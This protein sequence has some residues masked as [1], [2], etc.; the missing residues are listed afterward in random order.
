MEVMID[1]ETMGMGPD[2]AIISIGAVK[3]DLKE[4]RLGD[5][6]YTVVDLESSLAAGGTV[7]AGTILWWMGQEDAAREE[8]TAEDAGLGAVNIRVALFNFHSFF[9]TFNPV[10]GGVWGN[11]AAFDNV[12][13]ANAYQR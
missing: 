6:F 1:L 5:E 10:D 12:V 4:K 13:L 7:T 8:F 3:F 2:A 11:G 9:H